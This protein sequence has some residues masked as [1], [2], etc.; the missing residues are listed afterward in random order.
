MHHRWVPDWPLIFQDLIIWRF[1]KVPAPTFIPRC[2][3]QNGSNSNDAAG[4]SVPHPYCP[5]QIESWV[6][7]PKGHRQ[8]WPSLRMLPNMQRIAGTLAIPQRQGGELRLETEFL[9]TYVNH[10][11]IY[12]HLLQCLC[13]MYAYVTSSLLSLTPDWAGRALDP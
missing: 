1:G 4:K 12:I 9:F 11:S 3:Y 2:T 5:A 7:P 6:G 13:A 10:W 8:P